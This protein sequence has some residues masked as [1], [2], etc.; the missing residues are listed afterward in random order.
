MVQEVECFFGVYLLKNENPKY[1]GRT[2]IGYTVNP[3]RRIQQHNKGSKFGGARRTSGKGPWQMV[4][5]IHGFPND[6]SALR[7]EWSWQHPKSSR[8]LKTLSGKSSKESQFNYRFRIL[9]NMLRTAPW[10]RLPLTV[11]WLKQE[12]QV[13]FADNLQPPAHMPMAY[14]L[15]KSIKVAKSPKKKGKG[16]SDAAKGDKHEEV[17]TLSQSSQSINKCRCQVCV[18]RIQPT[19]NVMSCLYPRCSMVAHVICIANVF[20]RNT[21]ELLPVQGTCPLCRQQLL[22]GDLVR[23]KNGCYEEMENMTEDVWDGHWSQALQT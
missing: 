5:I 16:D 14:G 1:K 12:Y 17:D 13:D 6:V 18:K 21:D 4:L 10:S 3:S 20:L 22:W 2:Y 7:F 11:R 8:R 15:V 9:S 19:D 23:K